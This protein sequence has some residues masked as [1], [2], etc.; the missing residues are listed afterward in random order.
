MCRADGKK[1]D[2]LFKPELTPK[3]MLSLGVFGG[4]YMRD[5]IKEFPRDWFAKAKFAPKG[6]HVPDPKLNYFK[7]AASQPLSVWQK[8]DGSTKMILADG[9]SGIVVIIWDGGFPK[10]TIVR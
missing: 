8:K 6:S 5:C 10:R 7:V 1:F 4:I 2:P 9:F 3:Q